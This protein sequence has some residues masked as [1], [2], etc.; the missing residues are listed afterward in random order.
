MIGATLFFL[1]I[2]GIPIG[3]C[4]TVRLAAITHAAFGGGA[5]LRV[6]VAGFVLANAAL[7]LG[8]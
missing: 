7:G 3:A 2:L 8:C 1:P 6:A 5:K 4:S